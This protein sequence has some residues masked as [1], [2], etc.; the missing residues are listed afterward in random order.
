MA[1]CS[2]VNSATGD[3]AVDASRDNSMEHHH[4]HH[5][6]FHYHHHHDS[7][8]QQQEL[9]DD[10]DSGVQWTSPDVTSPVN[11]SSLYPLLSSDSLSINQSISVFINSSQH[12]TKLEWFNCL[13]PLQ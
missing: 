12:K 8:L 9:N 2:G 5:H 11:V 13:L 7:Q 6:H 3:D 4:H 1:A 10:D